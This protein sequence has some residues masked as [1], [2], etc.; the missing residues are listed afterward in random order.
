MHKQLYLI[1]MGMCIEKNSLLVARVAEAISR[2]KQLCKLKKHY[3]TVTI[4]E[5]FKGHYMVGDL[6]LHLNTV[7]DASDVLRAV[8]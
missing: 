6:C 8:I 3:L 4:Y 1:W 7:N 2:L 5:T